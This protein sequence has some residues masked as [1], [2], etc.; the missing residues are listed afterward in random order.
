M[1]EGKYFK[2]G[3]LMAMA[4]VQGGSGFP[5]FAPSVYK[6]LCGSRLEEIC[7]EVDE[8]PNIEVKQLLHQVS[9]IKY[10]T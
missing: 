7:V 4:I 5:F 6:Y 1:Q 8:V 2:V 10:R 3:Q 9:M